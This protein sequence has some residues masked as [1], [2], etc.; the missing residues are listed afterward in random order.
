[1]SGVFVT[2]PKRLKSRQNERSA[3]SVCYRFSTL[4]TFRNRRNRFPSFAAFHAKGR[5]KSSVRENTRRISLSLSLKSPHAVSFSPGPVDTLKTLV[6]INPASREGSWRRTRAADGA[7]KAPREQGCA[8]VSATAFP[9]KE[10]VAG[11]N[12]G[13][14]YAAAPSSPP[15][16]NKTNPPADE[17][18][19]PSTARSPPTRAQLRY[20]H[21]S[22]RSRTPAAATPRSLFHD[23]IQ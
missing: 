20:S 22:S 4:M 23:A 18:R 5:G 11:G 16:R 14:R 21:P 1:M 13:I 7:Q 2:E 17:K 19:F 15:S 10:N 3:T 6:A 9:R 8:L 12:L